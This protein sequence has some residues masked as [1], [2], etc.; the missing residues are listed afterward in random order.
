MCTHY[1]AG[2]GTQLTRMEWINTAYLRKLDKN[3]RVISR[4]G[5]FCIP[6]CD[7]EDGCNR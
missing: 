4:Q 6:G 7:M 1:L 5:P 2:Y 3:Y